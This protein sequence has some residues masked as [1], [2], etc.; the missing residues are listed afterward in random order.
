MDW[1]G[2]I[3]CVNKNV[4]EVADVNFFLHE[5]K[6]QELKNQVSVLSV[7]D[8]HGIDLYD[9]TKMLLMENMHTPN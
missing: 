6:L 5:T 4:V 2:P 7:S 1:D 3:S 9:K 8:E